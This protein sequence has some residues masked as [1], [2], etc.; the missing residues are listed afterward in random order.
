MGA[1]GVWETY[2]CDLSSDIVISGIVSRI[3]QWESHG[4]CFG[5]RNQCV[6]PGIGAWTE[7]G[8]T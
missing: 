8:V 5:Q 1:G 4:C 7:T 6:A 3:M 2:A